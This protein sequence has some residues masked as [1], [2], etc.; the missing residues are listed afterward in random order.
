ME[1]LPQ[2]GLALTLLVL[3]LGIKHGFDADHLAT[4]DGMTRFN[5][6]ANPNLAR[7]CG[8]LFSLGHGSVVVGVA[9]AAHW[10]AK[11]W[12]APEWLEGFGAFTSI[13]FLSLL[14]LLNLI[15]V[16]RTPADETVRPAGVK[17][18]FLGKLQHAGKPSLIALVGALFALSFDT[19]SQAALF[20]L[21]AQQ[22]GEWWRA[23]T[24]GLAFMAGMLLTDGVNGLWIAKIMR[25]TDRQAL[26]AS[27]LMGLT[28]AGLSLAVAALGAAKYAS[29]HI[30]GWL[31]G[32]E[33]ITGLAVFAIV[34]TAFGAGRLISTHRADKTA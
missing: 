11:S 27:R 15:A 31:E 32:T 10:V 1:Q 8:V 7:Y 18:R 26:I 28:V 29:P 20:A 21:S 6:R 9:T 5:H 12:T 24:L 14:G 34:F 2:D 22:Q 33:L 25:N 30:E 23:P 19:L 4:I 16:I 3:T 13:F 17:G